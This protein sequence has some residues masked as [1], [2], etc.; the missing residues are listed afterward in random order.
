MLK[1]C[2]VRFIEF[3]SIHKTNVLA[4][5]D[6]Q[7]KEFKKLLDGEGIGLSA[8][9]S[10]IGKVADRPPFEPHLDKFKRA[11]ELCGVFGTRG[12]RVFSYY[13]PGNDPNFDPAN[14]PQY[15]DEVI[16]RMARE[17]RDRGEEQRRAVPRERAPH[18]RRLAG[19]RRG[20]PRD[21]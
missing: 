15:R 20:H 2:R 4:L 9:G 16:R 18:L 11:I 5:S 6:E 19:P 1:A 14:W 17:G 3:R 12:I 10:P 8:I 13:P 7:I 21:A